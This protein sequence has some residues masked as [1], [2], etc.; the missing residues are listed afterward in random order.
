MPDTADGSTESH[1]IDPYAKGNALWVGSP[2]ARPTDVR[3]LLLATSGRERPA[4]CHESAETG[5]GQRS[6]GSILGHRAIDLPR[7]APC[8]RTQDIR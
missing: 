6:A 1:T 5:Q 4:G 2:A 8:G 7:D 3:A